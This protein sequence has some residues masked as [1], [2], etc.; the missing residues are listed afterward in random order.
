MYAGA[1]SGANNVGAGVL[2]RARPGI[3]A[4]WGRESQSKRAEQPTHPSVIPRS[5]SDEES[6]LSRV[7]RAPP[8]AFAWEGV[9]SR[10]SLLG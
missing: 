4:L 7:A 9:P 2:A 3:C 6:A 8:P 5:G 10:R 1:T